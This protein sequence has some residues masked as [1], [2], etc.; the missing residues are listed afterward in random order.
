MTLHCFVLFYFSYASG[1]AVEVIH[2]SLKF[3]TP[4][5]DE[6]SFASHPNKQMAESL[7]I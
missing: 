1:R 7:C 3:Y 2:S 4:Q 6:R 5:E